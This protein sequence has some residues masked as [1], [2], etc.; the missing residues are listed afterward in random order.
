M[1]SCR[2]EEAAGDRVFFQLATTIN[3]LE[4]FNFSFSIAFS[5]EDFVSK[6]KCLV[7]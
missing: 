3:K 1:F 5:Q 4:E 2:K 7:R 6:F